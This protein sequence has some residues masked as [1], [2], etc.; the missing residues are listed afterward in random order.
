MGP[1]A[2]SLCAKPVIGP[3]MF[4]TAQCAFPPLFQG[5]PLRLDQAGAVASASFAA[6]VD[7]TY[8]LL[9]RFTFPNRQSM[10]GDRIV[11]SRHD[12]YCDGRPYGQVPAFARDGLG[13]PIPLHIVIRRASDAATVIERTVESLCINAHGADLTKTRGIASVTLPRGKYSASIT[14]V[15]QQPGL[16]GVHAEVMLAGP[17]MK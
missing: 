15:T 12:R 5:V 4:I 13:Q 8:R 16:A 1:I 3:L 10:N 7:T 11:G 17:R 2:Y 6:P 14:N 9:I